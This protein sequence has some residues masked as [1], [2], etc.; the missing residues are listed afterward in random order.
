[1]SASAK[2]PVPQVFATPRPTQTQVTIVIPAATPTPTS[3]PMLQDYVREGVDKVSITDIKPTPGIPS[4]NVKL[5]VEKAVEKA[6]EASKPSIRTLEISKSNALKQITSVRSGVNMAIKALDN[7]DRYLEL[8]AY[9]EVWGGDKD[10][11]GNYIVTAEGAI[12]HDKLDP[13]LRMELSIY[14]AMDYEE[15]WYD[16]RLALEVTRDLS[17]DRFNLNIMQIEHNQEIQKKSIEYGVYAQ[18]AGIAQLQS[19]LVLQRK[20]L[21][22]TENTLETAKKRY[23][24]GDISK[25]EFDKAQIAYDKAVLEIASSERSLKS[26]VTS[27]NKT[28][29]ENLNTT[30][31]DFDISLLAPKASNRSINYYLD[32]ATSARSEVI[33]AAER[34]RLAEAEA[35]YYK[36]VYKSERTFERYEKIQA[37][38]EAVLEYELAVN[39]VESDVRSAYKQLL[40]LRGSSPYYQRQ[41]EITQDSYERTQTMYELGMVT[42][43]AVDAAALQ[44]NQAELQLLNN[45]ISIWTQQKLLETI[46]GIGPG[47]LR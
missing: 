16:D 28:L 27:F 22:N 13:D 40:A 43:S 46:C 29:G 12:V 6:L 1:M 32:K 26:Q 21:K 34:K 44:V 47:N 31:S 14:Q 7:D 2:T 18:Y 23:E 45:R 15:L 39:A 35:E 4:Y 38:D 33:L 10:S 30:Y 42:L 24:L 19:S 11:K 20:S 25:A 41:V 36:A 8:K 3:D 5:S 9:D 37:A 17:Y